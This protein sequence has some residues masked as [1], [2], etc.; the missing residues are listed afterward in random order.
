MVADFK[1]NPRKVKIAGGSA[2]GSMD[3]LVVAAAFKRRRV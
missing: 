3:H 1:E 2:R